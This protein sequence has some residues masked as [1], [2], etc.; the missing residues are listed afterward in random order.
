MKI[1]S[2]IAL[3]L[4]CLA[5]NIGAA[6][7]AI[8][9][10]AP[11][12]S[13]LDSYGNRVSLGDYADKMVILE[14]TNHLCPFVQKHYDSGSM[15]ALQKKY[16]GHGVVWLSVISSAEGKQGHVS[17]E[18]ANQ[19]TGSRE[20]MPSAVLIDAEGKMGRLYGA[21]TTPHM[22]IIDRQGILRYMGA[23]DSIRS[24]N[25]ADIPRATNYLDKGMSELLAG[26]P[27]SEA[28]TRAYGCTVKY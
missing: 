3:A 2:A 27:V 8:N 13:A 9:Q 23:I 17:P 12:F 5:A 20:A 19:L 16:T 15:Q 7:A 14:W 26:R 10:P 6:A 22:Y 18:Q 28:V 25:T 1:L 24:A 4:T 11:A 21:K